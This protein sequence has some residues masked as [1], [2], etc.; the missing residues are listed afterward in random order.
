M[1]LI[2]CSLIMISFQRVSKR[3]ILPLQ[4]KGTVR[5]VAFGMFRRNESELFYA[6]REVSLHVERGEFFGIVGANG[7]GKSTL[8][9][10]MAGIYEADEGCV[11][12]EGRVSPF[13]ELGIGFNPELSARENVVLNGLLLGIGKREVLDRFSDIIAFAG[14]E[15]FVEVPLKH[16]SSGMQA[17]LAFSVAIQVEADVYLMDEVLAVGDASFQEQCFQVF[18]GWKSVG[19]TVVLVSHSME[20]IRKFCDRAVLLEGGVVVK[21]GRV[22]EVVKTYCGA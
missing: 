1:L 13:L 19:K 2:F 6:L 3:F 16:Y 5:E 15:R 11:R 20:S 8:L 17:R 14:L 9:K 21:E 10:V 18:R 4:R 22:D 7:G 12:I